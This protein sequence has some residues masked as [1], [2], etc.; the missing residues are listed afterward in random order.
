[1]VEEGVWRGPIRLD[2]FRDSGNRFSM[3]HS[4]P[5]GD[6]YEIDQDRMDREYGA[7]WEKA[8]ISFRRKAE[9]LGLK[10]KI[11]GMAHGV[12][13][14]REDLQTVSYEDHPSERMDT[15]VDDLIERYG[16][17]YEMMIRDIVATVQKPIAEEMEH[18]KGAAIGRIACYLVKGESKNIHARIHSLLHAIPR[19]AAVSG[20]RSMRASAEACGVSVQWIKVG[21]DNWCEILGIPVPAEGKKKPEAIEKYRQIATEDHW[22]HR[23]V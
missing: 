22:R 5:T 17:Q 14:L 1:L 13:P 2:G 7:A 6:L 19:L 21:R 9:S 8:P 18:A 16:S 23:T 11:D 20:F 4:S 15:L 10:P 3:L 12:M